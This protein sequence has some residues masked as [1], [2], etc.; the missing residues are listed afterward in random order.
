MQTHSDVKGLTFGEC[1]HNGIEQAA[2]VLAALLILEPAQVGKVLHL[3]LEFL[4]LVQG[5]FQS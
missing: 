3:V 1:L 5:V 2:D 4:D